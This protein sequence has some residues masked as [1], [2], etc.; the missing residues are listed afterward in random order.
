[1][2]PGASNEDLSYGTGS[3]GVA[4]KEYVDL[5]VKF[6]PAFLRKDYDLFLLL[7]MVCKGEE[8]ASDQYLQVMQL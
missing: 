2:L 1:M 8:Y 5:R 6:S 7:F 4:H 3:R